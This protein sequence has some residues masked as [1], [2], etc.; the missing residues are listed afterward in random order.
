SKLLE[1]NPFIR[2]VELEN[3]GEM[4][5]NPELKSIIE[6]AYRHNVVIAC[7][8]GVNLNYVADNVLESL[9][10]YRFRSLL[11]S[12]DGASP[13][14]YKIYRVGGD[15]NRVIAAI[16]TINHYKK[17]Y[18]SKHPILTWQFVVFGHNEHEIQSAKKM[19][20]DL[21]MEFVPK[22]SWDSSY[23]PIRDK[24]L[25]MAETGWPAVT[26]EQFAEVMGVDY[27]RGVC[28]ALWH[29]PRI[30]WDGKILGCCWNS[31]GEFGGN[32]F[33][34]G[35]LQSIS[36]QGIEYARNMLRGK[37]K[38]VENLPCSTCELYLKMKTSGRYLKLSEIFYPFYPHRWLYNTV[39]LLYR[40]SG[41]RYL[42][43]RLTQSPWLKE[44]AGSSMDTRNHD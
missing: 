12:I 4:F 23:S 31:W 33:N 43:R 44:D 26:R 22:M 34:D 30:N 13:E 36:H 24:K 11:C 42:R 3:R 16:Q 8:S 25:V 28:S 32:A 5:L 1:A 9:V 15:F 14:T 19:A 10:K 18:N 35:Y 29:S 40:I 39:Y 37:A 27:M 17:L 20:S 6:Y 7:N 2:E 41:V 38:P 21:G